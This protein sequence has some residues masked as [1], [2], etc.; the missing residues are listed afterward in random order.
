MSTLL[1]KAKVD[2]DHI[3]HQ[4]GGQQY[5]LKQYYGKNWAERWKTL[6]LARMTAILTFFFNF[7]M[8]NFLNGKFPVLCSAFLVIVDHTKHFYNFAF[9]HIFI[10]WWQWLNCRVVIHVY[11]NNFKGD[12]PN[13]TLS[14]IIYWALCKGTWSR[15][16]L[17]ELKVHWRGKTNTKNTKYR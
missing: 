13:H 3:I 8:L 17:C 14:P 12:L 9:T 4:G 11:K 16:I 1:Q 6:V 7:E 10:Q 5:F 2:V 15:H